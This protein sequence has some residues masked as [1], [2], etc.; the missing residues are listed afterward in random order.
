MVK[1]GSR[2]RKDGRRFGRDRAVGLLWEKAAKKA[3]GSGV[4]SLQAADL[5]TLRLSGGQLEELRGSV[6]V[7]RRWLDIDME[8]ADQTLIKDLVQSDWEVLAGGGFQ[9][10]RVDVPLPSGGGSLDMVGFW[11]KHDKMQSCPGLCA[12]EKKVLSWRGFDRKVIDL[13]QNVRKKFEDLLQTH[14][15]RE[16]SG[17]LLSVSSVKEGEVDETKLFFFSKADSQWQ[18]LQRH[19]SGWPAVLP[20]LRSFT[21]PRGYLKDKKVASIGSFLEALGKDRKAACLKIP[22]WSNGSIPHVTRADFRYIKL[23]QHT[24]G[25]G[26]VASL[27]TLRQIY[28]CI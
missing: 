24:G 2:V 23:E 16:F 18:Q 5:A 19:K 3:L 15:G 28:K 21:A 27:D 26:F 14:M 10:T 11:G 4:G 6:W 13:K 25:K 20:K 12:Y 8:A 17:Q 9:V 22:Q 1:Y 7:R